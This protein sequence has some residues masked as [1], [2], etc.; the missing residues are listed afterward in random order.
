M[1][2]SETVTCDDYEESVGMGAHSTPSPGLG[3]VIKR[4]PEDFEVW[5]V[6][7]GGLDARELFELGPTVLLPPQRLALLAVRKRDRETLRVAMD[8]R[9]ALGARLR[10]VKAYGLKDRRAV[11][12]QFLVVPASRVLDHL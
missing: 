8:L 12:W 3:G 4:V 9:A 6:I 2:V 11:A 5:E 7:E 10:S 1:P